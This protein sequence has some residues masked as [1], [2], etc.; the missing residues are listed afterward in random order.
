MPDNFAA[1]GLNENF[2]HNAWRFINTFALFLALALIFWALSAIS[3]S[4]KS[5]C[6]ELLFKGLTFVFKWG[7][8]LILLFGNID[9][10]IIYSTLQLKNVSTDAT[11][12]IVGLA[13]SIVFL[14]I[15]A[16]AMILS[17][18]VVRKI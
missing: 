15:L 11:R 16:L 8:L 5:K 3:T 9:E 7:G 4:T 12:D 13:L 17:L 1:F 6:A 2:V 14:V 10:I 18:Y